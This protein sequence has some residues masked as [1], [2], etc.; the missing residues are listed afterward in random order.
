MQLELFF[1]RFCRSESPD[2]DAMVSAN[3]DNLTSADFESAI[4]DKIEQLNK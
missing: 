2:V 1:G 3:L 4:K